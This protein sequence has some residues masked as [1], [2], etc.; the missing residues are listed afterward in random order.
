MQ[1]SKIIVDTS[2]WIDYFQEEREVVEFIEKGLMNDMIYTVGPIIA[3][4]LQGVKSE[5]EYE[6]LLNCIEAVPAVKTSIQDWKKAGEL[7]NE[8]RR[9]GIT[10]F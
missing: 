9:N 1:N 7:A 4:L 6:I 10:E 3:E 2:R 8:L 5:N